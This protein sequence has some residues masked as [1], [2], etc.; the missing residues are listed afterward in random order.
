M[1]ESVAAPTEQVR[2]TWPAD[3][4]ENALLVNQALVATPPGGVNGRED[5]GVY[6]VLGHVSAPLAASPE[7]LKEIMARTN[8][9]LRISVRGSFYLSSLRAEELWHAL[10]AS[11]GKSTSPSVEK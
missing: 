5:D 8:G 2:T 6:L 4:L 3:A 10:G 9:D 7:D 11:L 1:A